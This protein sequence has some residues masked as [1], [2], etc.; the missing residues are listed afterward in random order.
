MGIES[1]IVATTGFQRS[2]YEQNELVKLFKE[3]LS[4]TNKLFEYT[5]FALRSAKD[6]FEK[7]GHVV[8]VRKDQVFRLFHDGRRSMIEPD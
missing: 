5:S 7:G 8:D 1:K 2:G 4:S 6:I 3:T